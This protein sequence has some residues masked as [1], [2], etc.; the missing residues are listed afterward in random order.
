MRW[1]LKVNQNWQL[2]VPK[3][4]REKL[5]WQGLRELE[6]EIVGEEI[7]LRKVSGPHALDRPLST[8][9]KEA[10]ERSKQEL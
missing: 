5:K 4:M 7:I 10:M 3:R 1:V 9:L 6:M 2:H 8:L